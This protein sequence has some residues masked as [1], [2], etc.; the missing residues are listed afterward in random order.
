MSRAFAMAAIEH[1]SAHVCAIHLDLAWFCFPQ[2]AWSGCP[3]NAHPEMPS[4][5]SSR[6]PRRAVGACY[7][8]SK[9]RP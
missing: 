3:Q 8:A 9:S 2:S 7:G 1:Q 6:L 5:L 4:S